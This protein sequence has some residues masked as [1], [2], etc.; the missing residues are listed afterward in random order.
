MLYAWTYLFTPGVV[1]AG[2]GLLLIA[3]Y[4]A[5]P[6]LAVLFAIALVSVYFYYRR[7]RPQIGVD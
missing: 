4:S 3:V 1:L 6:A 2:L 7:V 5:P